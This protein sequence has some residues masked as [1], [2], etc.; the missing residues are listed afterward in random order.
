M[1]TVLTGK[2]LVIMIGVDLTQ[3]CRKNGQTYITCTSVSK[4]ISL[5]MLRQK[6]FELNICFTEGCKEA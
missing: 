3:D 1:S 4:A 2:A 5:L 6:Q